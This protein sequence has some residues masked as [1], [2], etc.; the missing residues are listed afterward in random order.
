MPVS[1]HNHKPRDR[2]RKYSVNIRTKVDERKPKTNIEK[3]VKQND[4]AKNIDVNTIPC[5]PSVDEHGMGGADLCGNLVTVT[6]KHCSNSIQALADSGAVISCISHELYRQ[7][8]RKV[9]L[10]NTAIP[11]VRGVGGNVIPVLGCVNIDLTIGTTQIT[12]S[13]HVLQ[14]MTR[15]LILGH[16]F[17]KTHEALLCF[18]TNKFKLQK[19]NSS[20]SL[21]TTNNSSL[22]LGQTVRIPPKSEMVV[23]LNSTE[24]TGTTAIIYPVDTLAKKYHV[25]GAVG[26][27][28]ISD[29]KTAFRLL[30]P[31][32][33]SVKLPKGTI[34]AFTE[35]I[36]ES[37]VYDDD[38]TQVN[39]LDTNPTVDSLHNIDHTLTDEQYINITKSLGFDLVSSDLTSAERRQLSIFLGK[40]RDLF[41]TSLKELGFTSIHQ[42]R[43]D[44]GDAT[45]MRQAPYRTTPEKR[46][47]IEHQVE[48]LLDSD[49]IE[50][51]V[52]E[53]QAPVVLV[54]KKDSSYRFAVD[55]RK[56]NQVTKP[57]SYPLPRIEDVFDS[58]GQEQ[59]KIFSTLDM[60][61]GF[62][63]IP[64]DPET[65][66]KTAFCTHAGVYQFKRLSFGLT[67]APSA[68]SMVMGEVLRGLTFKN[69]VI[70]VDDILVYSRNFIQHLQH[71]QQI[72][73]RIRK[74][75]LRLKPSKCNFAT[76]KVQYLGHMISKGGIEMEDAKLHNVKTF[77]TPNNVKQVRSFLG[78]CNFYRRFV[79]GFAHIARPLHELTEIGKIF[80]WNDKC[81][82]AFKQMKHLMTSEPVVLSYP[83]FNKPFIL[84]A[85]ASD[86]AIGYVLGQK[87]EK[88]R[89][90]AIAYAGRTLTK[91]EQKWKITDK[92]CLAVV[93]GVRHYKVYL[94][95]DKPFEIYT[96]HK[97]LEYLRKMKATSSRLYRWALEL[98]PLKATII[99]RAG[100]SHGNADAL[101]RRQ[102][103]TE[104]VISH[105]A[106]LPEQGALYPSSIP[107][108][109][110]EKDIQA[111]HQLQ[112]EVAT[113]HLFPES[114]PENPD[115]VWTQV[116]LTW[117]EIGSTH[118]CTIE[119]DSD[120]LPGANAQL[121]YI[122]AITDTKQT[123]VALQQQN[124]QDFADVYKCLQNDTGFTAQT[125]KKAENY[126]LKDSIL[127]HKP[128]VRSKIDITDMPRSEQLAV[129]TVLR[130]DLLRS[131]HDSLAGGGHQGVDRTYQAIKLKYFW[132]TMHGDVK[133]YV[134]SCIACQR[135]KR[136]YTNTKAPLN[137]LPVVDIFARWHI[138]VLGPLKKAQGY[139]YVLVMVD[140][141]SRWCEAF[142]MYTQEATEIAELIYMNIICRFG[143]PDT[144]LSDRGTNF[145][146]NVV[147]ELC[148]LF[149]I[150]KTETSSYHPQ[151]N[152][153]VER[154][155]S[156]IGSTL[157]TYINENQDNWPKLL[158]SIMMAHRMTPCTQSTH[159][160]PFVML[161]GRHCRLPIDVALQP[162]RPLS[163]DATAHMEQ[164]F[165]Q[166]A[167]A[168]EIGHQKV[169]ESQSRN[170]AQH[171]K[172]SATPTFQLCET[173]LMSN[174]AKKKGHTA[175]LLPKWLGPYY[176]VKVFTN[177]VYKLRSCDSHKAVKS[178]IHANRLKIYVDPD[179]RRTDPP[180][181]GWNFL[182]GNTEQSEGNQEPNPA[183]QE[184][185][186]TNLPPSTPTS[187]PTTSSTST[188]TTSTK[189]TQSKVQTDSHQAP[190]LIP[191]DRLLK[192]AW[193]NGRR[194]YQVKWDAKI[195]TTWEYASDLPNI[196]IR[197]FHAK[198]NVTG[199]TKKKNHT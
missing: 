4:Y 7:I 32:D 9:K 48:E 197:E 108:V 189:Q 114:D 109:G 163:K 115:K 63:Q 160:S 183:S 166:I 17:M 42:H 158:P 8:E 61:S 55:Y 91:D 101:S 182:T 24:C 107:E 46:A 90:Q 21:G 125:Q 33:R 72:F 88:G 117:P 105:P 198:Y 111:D 89:H 95:D 142:P 174:K 130:D 136:A 146:S 126:C 167:V 80:D 144:L 138:D 78:L 110:P 96:D 184:T 106:D 140:S 129:P 57:I 98:D 18:K 93:E 87:D 161:F 82:T 56:L 26:V 37:N 181:S 79:K 40:N 127:Y 12:H 31:N 83:Q 14:R 62:W 118:I 169:K 193:K 187:T 52:S 131:Y 149:E 171:D 86:Y 147:R 123:D 103:P 162:S 119:D 20:N 44:T 84:Y 120:S 54:K 121:Y 60:A 51:S 43:I 75:G 116:D 155:N 85:D 152:S 99:Y 39:L 94:Q 47:E 58:V 178:L 133:R 29:G 153:A 170:K 175:K 135:S 41:A 97:A 35:Q 22:K 104:V 150:T 34:V 164:V 5:I 143:A 148:R 15:A 185:T 128:V 36:H 112:P 77:P 199:K 92:E 190:K 137:P 102:W 165:E 13:F 132:P 156:T 53:W 194:I 195:P 74:A 124:D 157:R 11:A 25:A 122:N 59:A 1:R 30:N 186:Q 67:N 172:N 159:H 173:V 70:Y 28:E 16:D 64:L 145:M 10:Y 69:A 65:A 71:L 38:N 180:L 188:P 23:E 81:E 49:I 154:L 141:F 179:T 66:H 151:T 176:I 27:C 3:K 76:P 192:S 100:C 73:S 191:I 168:R 113:F 19:T 45:P 139:Q 50:P 2:H 177:N 68:F 6:V 134:E 196:V